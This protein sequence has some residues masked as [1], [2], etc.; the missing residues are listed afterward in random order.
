MIHTHVSLWVE[1]WQDSILLIFAFK[2]WVNLTRC[3]IQNSK[4][5]ISDFYPDAYTETRFPFF[6]LF[7]FCNNSEIATSNR[8][9]WKLEKL[10]K[11]SKVTQLVYGNVQP[12]FNLFITFS[13]WLLLSDTIYEKIELSCHKSERKNYSKGGNQ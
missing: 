1:E 9:N 4:K 12:E 5:P 13:P 6:F 7:N 11:L 3:W 10:G 8:W 2:L